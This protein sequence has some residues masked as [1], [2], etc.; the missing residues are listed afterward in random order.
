MKDRKSFWKKDS[1]GNHL[2][3]KVPI[4]PLSFDLVDTRKYLE[5][6]IK[7]FDSIDYIYVVDKN[8]LLGVFSSKRLYSLPG[9][10]K[11]DKISTKSLHTVKPTDKREY[12]AYLSLEHGLSS[13]PIVDKD[14]IFLGIVTRHTILQILHKK[15]LEDAFSVAGIHKSHAHIDNIFQISIFQS[16]RHRIIWLII[17]L[18]GGILAAEI[19]G[20]FETTLQQNLILAAFI[21]LIVYIADAV[22]TQLEA[23]AIRDFSLYKDISFHFYFIKQFSIVLIIAILLGAITTIATSFFINPIV[24]LVVGISIFGATLSSIITGLFIPF[25]FRKLKMDPVNG[26]GPIGTIIQDILSIVIYFGIASWLL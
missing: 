5:K 18:L 16:I 23:F 13:I 14:N 10:T 17:G 21:P 11:V 3:A 4:V 24:S 7:N 22:G 25:T 6:N 8:S 19:I 15:H 20:S 26:S 12:A 1:I 9:K 2:T